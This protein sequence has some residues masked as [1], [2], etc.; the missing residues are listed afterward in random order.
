MKV[1]ICLGKAPS[2]VIELWDSIY[3]KELNWLPPVTKHSLDSDPYQRSSIYFV[4]HLGAETIGTIRLVRP[5]NGLLPAELNAG[6]FPLVKHG[7]KI[8]LT[9]LMVAKQYRGSRGP[10]CPN[11]VFLGL[12]NSAL[13][14]AASKMVVHT[15]MDVRVP[16]A[17]HSIANK[18]KKLNFIGLGNEYPD[19]LG[20]HF[21]NCTTLVRTND[22]YSTKGTHGIGH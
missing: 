13:I 22:L 3:H 20:S 17:P 16:S 6:G 7:K 15:L 11:G 10:G 14:F 9:R 19:P 8:E 1:T 18:L 4:A 5:I 12:M 2:D 21:L